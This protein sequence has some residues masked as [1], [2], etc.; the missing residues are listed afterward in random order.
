[1]QEVALETRHLRLELTED[2]AEAVKAFDEKAP[3]VRSMR[4]RFDRSVGHSRQLYV[5]RRAVNAGRGSA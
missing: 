4:A 1:M 5:K 3:A 2:F